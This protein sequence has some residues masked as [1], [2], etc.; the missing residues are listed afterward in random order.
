MQTR[1]QLKRQITI[2][3]KLKWHLFSSRRRSGNSSVTISALKATVKSITSMQPPILD[4]KR[5]V[6]AAFVQNHRPFKQPTASIATWKFANSAAFRA[7]NAMLR[8]AWA[9]SNYCKYFIFY[10]L[11]PPQFDLLNI[12]SIEILFSSVVGHLNYYPILILTSISSYSGC[13]DNSVDMNACCERCK[14]MYSI[15]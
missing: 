2:T 10:W 14:Q 4:L 8:F 1:N 11:P 5:N 12:F 6:D 7:S 3:M 15:Q 13:C 9:A